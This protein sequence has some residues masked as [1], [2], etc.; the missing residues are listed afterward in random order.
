M[1]LVSTAGST[2]NQQLAPP[3]ISQHIGSDWG[4]TSA[5]LFDAS[6]RDF[7]IVLAVDAVSGVS[8]TGI[9]WCR[10]IGVNTFRVEEIKS[11]LLAAKRGTRESWGLAVPLETR[12]S[13]AYNLA[14]DNM[15][16]AAHSSGRGAERNRRRH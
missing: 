10:G 3:K 2:R 13:A 4:E 12:N 1:A 8:E 15:V 11:S 16:L 6:E 5:T 14:F 9:E 7:R